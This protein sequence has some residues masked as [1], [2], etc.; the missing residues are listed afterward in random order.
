MGKSTNR[1]GFL[2]LLAF[3]G[4]LLVMGCGEAF[5]PPNAGETGKTVAISGIIF[6]QSNEPVEGTLVEITS[7]PQ[8]KASTVTDTSG[9]YSFAIQVE[10]ATN[11]TIRASKENFE[12]VTKTITVSGGQNFSNVNLIL[13]SADDDDPGV[14]GEP[15]GP[16]AI[17]LTN[18]PL[19][20]INIAETGD[21]VSAPFTFVVQDS[22]GRPVE[23]PVE[24]QF[25]IISGPGGGESLVPSSVT[26]DAQGQVT[27]TLFSGNKAGPVKVQALIQRDD[28][29]L[30]IR[31]TPVLI[32]IHGGFPDP[33]H[34]S[35]S[36]DKFNF[37][38]YSINN[39]RNTVNVILGD[40]FSNPVKP[41]TVVYFETTG[42]II[43]GSAA[44]DND[45]LASVE[46][47]SGDPR[48]DDP[49]PGSGGRPGYATVTATTVGADN[50][51]ISKEVIVVFSTSQ[52]VI[53]GSPTTF[54]IP[55]GGGASFSYTVTDLNGNPMATGT[56]IAVKAGEGIEVTGD[57]AFTLGNFLFPGPGS[58]EF[59]FS[60][61]DIDEESS[62]AASLTLQ[63][64]VTTPSGN[65]TTYS[66]I[67][68]TRH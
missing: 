55:P 31:S 22:A 46:L 1:T 65:T 43:Q 27:T 45:G 68:G 67:S 44:T 3:A 47:I 51:E 59:S 30:I 2:L 18:T 52:A 37:E 62:A 17:I 38:G 21:E 60:I 40:K 50:N 15:E 33:E 25:S 12:P 58:T 8:N 20:A 34:F 64:T 19:Q 26:T 13:S 14:D 35:I 66:G 32:A 53:S 16:A 7:P 24:V 23:E 11:V 4:A 49:V 41:G 29:G 10:S 6:N 42:G 56:Q 63:I 39:Q 54:N 5:D 28:I 9:A 61:R 48:P 36:V 57:A